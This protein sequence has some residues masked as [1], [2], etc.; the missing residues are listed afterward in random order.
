MVKS[1][2]IRLSSPLKRI[3]FVVLIIGILAA[4][5]PSFAADVLY[6]KFEAGI[7]G[8]WTIVD[9]S[10]GSCGVWQSNDAGGRGNLTGGFGGFAIV[11]SD[12]EGCAD[13]ELISPPFTVPLN[14]RLTFDTD[15]NQL[16]DMAE[17]D[18]TKD[19]GEAWTNLLHWELDQRGPLEVDID[20]SAYSGETVQIRF[21][22]VAGQDLWWEVDN[23]RLIFPESDVDGFGNVYN[24]SAVIV[25]CR[26]CIISDVT[27][28][29]PPTGAPPSFRINEIVSFTATEVNTTAD[30]S[31][32]FAYLPSSPYFYKIINRAWTQI[33]PINKINGIRDVSLN[34]NTLRFTI[35]D[36]SNS[37]KDP[38]VGTIQDPIAAGYMT[39]GIHVSSSDGECFIATAVSGNSMA[40]HV[41]K[42][43]EFRD[44]FLLTNS[45]GKALVNFYY[46]HSPAVA[47]FI[48]KH[49]K[50]KI[51]IR[52]SLLPI[53]GMSWVALT[54][55]L[56]PTLAFI[57]LFIFSLN[58]LARIRRKLRN[59]QYSQNT[60]QGQQ[61]VVY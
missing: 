47:N 19:K 24:N 14:A 52:L 35:E 43:R 15:Y 1:S 3:C 22:N 5:I 56:I 28:P 34:G 38:T 25:T 13:T 23:V 48:T 18:I 49:S 6:E 11:D 53:L 45:V 50:L 57:L 8:T 2:A 17:V 58:S 51:I 9:N 10:S 32:D 40:P 46:I 42:L 30:I 16:A 36:D 39:S 37:D 20:L 54:L 27:S 55:G 33:Y 4:G 41:K 7:P 61:Q 26:D 21:V 59:N 31:M 12:L 60:R 44:R 29:D